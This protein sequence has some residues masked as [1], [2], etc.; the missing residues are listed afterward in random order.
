MP[1]LTT[2]KLH[3]L[4]HSRIEGK[5]GTLCRAIVVH[6]DIRLHTHVQ[7]MGQG[8]PQ[9]PCTRC[10]IGCCTALASLLALAHATV[11]GEE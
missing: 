7:S 2:S 9:Q 11:S 1:V 6:A 10:G 4:V 5:H 8:Q 3:A